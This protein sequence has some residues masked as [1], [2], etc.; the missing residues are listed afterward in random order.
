MSKIILTDTEWMNLINPDRELA[1]C[2][3][4]ISNLRDCITCLAASGQ[5][6]PGWLIEQLLDIYHACLDGH[7]MKTMPTL[8]KLISQAK[9]VPQGEARRSGGG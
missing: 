1:P 9:A 7:E 4:N 3:A 6:V 8:N 5:N 2:C